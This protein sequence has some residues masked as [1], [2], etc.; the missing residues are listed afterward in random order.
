MQGTDGENSGKVRCTVSVG[1]RTLIVDSDEAS[2]RAM[3][4]AVER[5]GI[6]V[7]REMPHG[8]VA[9]HSIQE[10]LPDLV[11]AAVDQPVHRSLQTIE[12]ARAVAPSAM[13]VAYAREWSPMA[14]RRL[15]QCG[16]NDVIH[17]RITREAVAPVVDRALRKASAPAGIPAVCSGEVIAVVGPKGGIGKTT[18]STNVA[19]AIAAGG[20][21]S[22]LLIDLDTRFGDAAVMLNLQ[23]DYTVAE[24]A[25]E[26]EEL[27]RERLREMLVR[28]ESGA[29]VLAAPHDYR[30]WLNCS[31]DQIR[32]LIRMAATMFDVVVLDTPGTFNDVVGTAIEEAG[33]VMVIT[34]AD[35][36]SL[37]NT[38][39]LLEHFRLR[40]MRDGDVA[41]ALVHGS[42]A[43]AAGLSDV[44]YALGRKVDYE[45]PF[46]GAVQKAS[47]LGIPVV[48]R[49]PGSAASV[50]FRRIAA[51]LSGSGGPEGD[52]G[53]VAAVRSRF[54]GVF[55]VS[56]AARR[57]RTA[58]AI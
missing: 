14:E 54:F 27:D 17:G 30:R 19:A 58:R 13:I 23:A 49:R 48:Q 6:T 40:G 16:V 3:R 55:G 47:Q 35:L 12:F 24:A 36:T 7:D 39:L 56:R 52:G 20:R 21:S 41:V 37:K 22:V 51:D 10:A 4:G 5:A 53:S 26:V 45:V 43:Q 8:L 18:T 28:H 38:T 1:L 9:Q 34:S 44:E 57:E 2:R 42:A 32:A 29:W 46:D 11:F 25:V 15:M 33:R 50:A 31:P